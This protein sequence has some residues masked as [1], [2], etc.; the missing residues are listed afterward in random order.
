MIEEAKPVEIV[1]PEKAQKV[2]D[3]VI[4]KLV[5]IVISDQREYIGKCA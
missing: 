2:V 5:R 3:K 1:L 4:D